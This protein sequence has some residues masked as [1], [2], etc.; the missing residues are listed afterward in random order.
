MSADQYMAL[1]LVEDGELG[2]HRVLHELLEK[3]LVCSDCAQ[4]HHTAFLM[5]FGLKHL[6]ADPNK[7]LQVMIYDLDGA[8]IWHLDTRV[9]RPEIH[10]LLLPCQPESL[11]CF[12]STHAGPL[13]TYVGIL[14]HFHRTLATT[15]SSMHS[16]LC[17]AIP[18]EL[19]RTR[20][21]TSF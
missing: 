12:T 3:H 4:M 6:R 15:D 8:S 16:R 10:G 17:R 14:N 7:H 2:G 9:S 13:V 1:H 18:A 19:R 21:R 5:E 11:L 20:T